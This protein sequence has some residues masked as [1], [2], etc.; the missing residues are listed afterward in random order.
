M[1]FGFGSL[2]MTATDY[3]GKTVMPAL[4]YSLTKLID[5]VIESKEIDKWKE[6]KEEEYIK[7][8]R[9]AKRK[10]RREAGESV[11]GSEEWEDSDNSEEKVEVLVPFDPVNFVA[12]RIL[13][14]RARG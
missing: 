4:D 6:A 3:L 13:E 8:R 10:Q 5:F 14:F 9:D 12:D 11:S 2:N 1:D 7:M